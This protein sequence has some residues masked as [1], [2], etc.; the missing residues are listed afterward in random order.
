MPQRDHL[1]HQ[2]KEGL[3]GIKTVNNLGATAGEGRSIVTAQCC[4]AKMMKKRKTCIMIPAPDHNLSNVDE[5]SEHSHIWTTCMPCMS[6]ISR[7]HLAAAAIPEACSD[8]KPVALGE[9]GAE[10]TAS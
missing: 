8:S 10:W 3:T 2:K 7:G 5:L 6:G 1:I 4:D 9:T